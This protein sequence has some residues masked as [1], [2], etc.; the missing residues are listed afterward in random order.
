M[1]QDDSFIEEQVKSFEEHL[2]AK[3]PI[4]QPWQFMLRMAWKKE[5]AYELERFRSSLIA[6]AEHQRNE[7]LKEV[8]SWFGEDYDATSYGWIVHKLDEARK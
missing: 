6:T 7:T 2:T 8:R 4:P 1:T 5:L 3:M